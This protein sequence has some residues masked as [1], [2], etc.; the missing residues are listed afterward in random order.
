MPQWHTDRIFAVRPSPRSMA[1]L[2]SKP[3]RV[4]PYGFTEAPTLMQ[5]LAD[6]SLHT[7]TGDASPLMRLTAS[8]KFIASSNRPA[9]SSEAST[10]IGP[11]MLVVSRSRSVRVS[12]SAKTKMLDDASMQTLPQLQPLV[13][14]HV[15][16]FRQ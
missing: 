5:V 15:S 14:P 7:H 3:A 16:H 13:P 4:A 2:A 6:R 11:W 10:V 9:S 1:S 12:L 8:P